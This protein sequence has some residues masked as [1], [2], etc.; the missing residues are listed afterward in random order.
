MSSNPQNQNPNWNTQNQQ[1]MQPGSFAAP[2]PNADSFPQDSH[3]VPGAPP[4]HPGGVLLTPNGYVVTR[5]IK[6]KTIASRGWS[7]LMFVLLALSG[8]GTFLTLAIDPYYLSYALTS[9]MTLAVGAG[10]VHMLESI[11]AELRRLG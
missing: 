2:Q 7:T 3:A 11:V 4:Y 8:I 1:P 9:T 10:V 5:A 6:Y